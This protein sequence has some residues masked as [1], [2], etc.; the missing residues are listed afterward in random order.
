MRITIDTGYTEPLS[1]RIFGHNLE[2]TRSA[3]NGGLSAQML[4]NRK[5]AGKPS[6]TGVAA[7]WE[8]IGD[9]A[10]FRTGGE[11]YTRHIGCE[12]M[13]RRNELQSLSAQNIRGGTC[14]IRQTGLYIEGGKAY[15]LH[16]AAKC[17]MPVRL[18]AALTNRDDNNIYAQISFA[19]IPGEWQR[20]SVK[21][22][23][24]ETDADASVRFTFTE[25]TQ[26]VFG[27]VSLMPADHFHGMRRDVVDC[28]RQIAPG[29][30]R[31]P[32]GNFAG[33][34]RWKDGMLPADMRGPLESLMENETQPY[35]HG[36]DFH[37]INTDDFIALC[38]EIGAEPFLTINPVWCSPEESAQWVEY[39]NGPADSEYGAKRAENGCAEPYNVRLWSLGNEM[40]YGHM[41]GPKSPADYAALAGTHADAMLSVDPELTLF[42]SGPYPNDDWARESAA[43]LRPVSKYVS[44]HHYAFADMDYTPEQIEKTYCSVGASAQGALDLAAR[45]RDSLD[46]FAPGMLISFDEWNLWYGWFRPSCVTE[47]I[48]TAKM[49]HMFINRSADLGIALGAYFQ[50]VNEG[51]I[52]VGPVAARLTADGQ[53]F[54][55]M[56]GHHGGR[57]CIIDC[58]DPFTAAATVKDGAVFVTLVND[59]FDENRDFTLEGLQG[60]AEGTLYTSDEVLPYTYFRK[61]ELTVKRDGGKLTVSVPPHSAAAVTVRPE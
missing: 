49:L 30:L 46:R 7:E 4:R 31:W 37:E 42:S 16:L 10:F 21:L 59:N 40:G 3:V 51:A 34:Y 26:V 61:T 19:L 32:G 48:F 38:R 47:G 58:A 52:E 43:A 6:P 29:V 17:F 15:E 36:Y 11:S 22:T 44:L 13:L 5:F 1:E 27:A 12:K 54:A 28:L 9:R 8:S 20:F 55:M 35:T 14:G 18:T 33:E 56:K 25:R 41:E 24:S 2:H 45:M 50:P 57:R 39:C 53:M 60:V 23:P